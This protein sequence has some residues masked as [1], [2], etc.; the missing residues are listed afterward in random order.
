MAGAVTLAA[1]LEVCL[2]IPAAPANAQENAPATLISADQ[3][4]HLAMAGEVVVVDV[5]SPQEWDHTGVPADAEMVTIHQ[6]DGLAG[7]VAAIEEALG[8]D[9][10]RPIAL[11]CARGNRST[12]ASLAL[13]EAGFTQ[14]YNIREGMLGNGDG[15]GW[16]ARELPTSPCAVC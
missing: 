11:I 7:F 4:R 2:A 13:A 10:S 6:P 14:I 9:R 3:A 8:A 12:R 1:F 5:R 16:L 15:P